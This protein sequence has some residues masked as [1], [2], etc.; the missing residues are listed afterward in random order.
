MARHQKCLLNRKETKRYMLELS[1]SERNNK[2]SRVS[3]EFIMRI[4]AELKE[5]LK[6]EIW[7]IPSLGK[8]I[9]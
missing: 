6:K 8:T 7:I 2:F 4:E 3:N 9:K 5:K 1:Q